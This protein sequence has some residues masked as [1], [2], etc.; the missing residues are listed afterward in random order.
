MGKILYEI[1]EGVAVVTM[2][3]P[4]NLN[5]LDE[6]MVEEIS[7]ALDRAENDAEANVVV[8]KGLDRAFSAGGDIG[9]FYKLIESGQDVNIDALI[10]KAEALAEQMKRMKKLVITSVSGAVAGAGV[11]L[12]ISGDF[13]ICADNAKFMLAF[14]NLGL[15]PDTGTV[16]L[17]TKSIGAARTMELAVTGRPM[18]AQE[19]FDR[20]LACRLTTQE[21]LSDVTMKFARK[22]A[23]GPLLSYQYIK[24]QVYCAAYKDYKEWMAETEKPAMQT[25]VASEDFKEGCRAFVEKRKPQFSGK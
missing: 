21:E 22:L 23:A 1:D 16:Y 18:K 25:A 4:K 7:A 13:M 19:A 2:N 10:A 15:V 14:V 6:A 8:L 17:L 24:K 5:A 20:G 9:F 3:S 11:S 12:A